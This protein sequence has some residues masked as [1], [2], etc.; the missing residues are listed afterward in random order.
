MPTLDFAGN[1]LVN[2]DR[3]LPSSRQLDFFGNPVGLDMTRA[4]AAPLGLQGMPPVDASN[5][6]QLP[7]L[8]SPM[9]PQEPTNEQ[10]MIYY[11]PSTGD[12][13][14]NGFQFNQRNASQALVSRQFAA[15]PHQRFTLPDTASDWRAMPTQEYEAYLNTIENPSFGR[16][17]GESW[18]NAWRGMGDIAVG[19]GLAIDQATTGDEDNQ[20][21]LNARAS[22]AREYEE[23]APFM[24]QMRDVKNVGDAAT[25]MSQMLVQGVPWL[26]ETAVSMAIGGLIGGAVSGGVGAPA[27][28]VEAFTAKEALRAAS[29]QLLRQ[30]LTRGAE[31]YSTALA[32]RQGAA[33]LTREEVV[34][35]SGA[36]ADD[37]N[38]F[39]NF[40]E[41][42][43][44][45]SRA[46]VGG[47]G[48]VQVGQ[49]AGMSASNYLTGVGDIRNS[50]ADAGGDPE[51]A[52]AVANIWGLAIPYAF[53]ESMGDLLVTQPVANLLPGFTNVAAR[54]TGIVDQLAARGVNALRS[55]AI[56]GPAEGLEEGA[57]YIITQQGV[58]GATNRPIDIDPI[59]LLENVVGGALAGTGLGGVTG[60]LG[61]P[62]VAPPAVSTPTTTTP[63]PPIADGALSGS[64]QIMGGLDLN[65][66]PNDNDPNYVGYQEAQ[67]MRTS[68]IE[69]LGDAPYNYDGEGSMGGLD[70]NQDP[71]D[72]N[73]NHVSPEERQRMQTNAI[74][75]VGPTTVT[76]PP[77]NVQVQRTP[78]E[79]FIDLA[80][81]KRIAPHEYQILREAVRREQMSDPTNP[82]Y[83]ETINYIN[84]A[85]AE[86]NTVEPEYD[87]TQPEL[88]PSDGLPTFG[89]HRLADPSV[90]QEKLRAD[91]IARGR[92]ADEGIQRTDGLRG[93]TPVSE[94]PA[95]LPSTEK[96][97][98]TRDHMGRV[99]GITVTDEAAIKAEKQKKNS[100][101]RREKRQEKAAL[102]KAEK[103]AARDAKMHELATRTE[104]DKQ[105][106]ADQQAMRPFGRQS[107]IRQDR[108]EAERRANEE[109]TK[110]TPFE[111]GTKKEVNPPKRNRLQEAG[112][113]IEEAKNAIPER[114]TKATPKEKQPRV[115]QE[116][117]RGNTAD[118][119]TA[120]ESANTSGT[121]SV[122]STEVN[123]VRV[124]KAIAALL[125]L[126]T[127]RGASMKVL[128]EVTK[129]KQHAAALASNLSQSDK[130]VKEGKK[131]RNID[132]DKYTWYFNNG[133]NRADLRAVIEYFKNIAEGLKADKSIISPDAKRAQAFHSQVMEEWNR[134]KGAPEAFVDFVT[135]PDYREEVENWV[136]SEISK[137]A[138]KVRNTAKEILDTTQNPKR[139]VRNEPTDKKL[140]ELAKIAD[141][142]P[143]SST[144][145]KQDD[146]DNPWKNNKG[147]STT[148]TRILRRILKEDF[149]FTFKSIHP[150]TRARAQ[151]VVEEINAA[152][153]K[154]GEKKSSLDAL[155]E[156]LIQLKARITKEEKPNR[157]TNET[158]LHKVI[159]ES[160]ARKAVDK[161]QRLI[162]EDVRFKTTHVL[163]NVMDILDRG[164]EEMMTAPNGAQVSLMS[165]VT[166]QAMIMKKETPEFKDLSVEAVETFFIQSHMQADAFVVPGYNALFVFA[167]YMKDQRHFITTLEHEYIAHG[168][169][170]ALFPD[171]VELNMFLQ[172]FG[173]IPGVQEMRNHL[174]AIKPEYGSKFGFS[175]F[176]QLEEV[177]AYHSMNGPLALERL[178]SAEEGIDQETRR[179]LWEDLKQLVKNWIAKIF[180]TEVNE[181]NDVMNDIVAALREHAIVGS[182]PNLMSLLDKRGVPK[183][184]DTEREAFYA[185][186]REH[187]KRA[188]TDVTDTAQAT[189]EKLA[190]TSTNDPLRPYKPQDYA[191]DALTIM[192][193]NE[194]L[195]DK[196]NEA[197]TRGG[198]SIKEGLAKVGRELV[199]MN[200]MALK[201]VLIEKM[202]RIMHNTIK[203]ARNLMTRIQEQRQYMSKTAKSAWVRRIWGD[204]YPGSNPE[205]LD[206]ANR[207]S[208]IA[209]NNRIATLSDSEVR[210][211]ARLRVRNLNGT[212]TIN[213]G[214]YD[215]MLKRGTLTKEEFYN[216]VE[217][218]TVDKNGEVTSNGIAKLSK[219]VIDL[220][221]E[222][223]A[224]ESRLMAESALN[225]LV[226]TNDAM[227]MRNETS[228]A[229]LLKDLEIKEKDR[230]FVEEA[231]LRMRK[232]Y[233]D[234]AF[235]KY[236][237]SNYTKRYDQQQM[238]YEVIVELQRAFHEKLKVADWT[239]TRT[240]RK[241]GTNTR[242]N[243]AFKWRELVNP[244][245]DVEPF[246]NQIRWF[247][248]YDDVV[249][250]N[251]MEQLNS[252]GVNKEQQFHAMNVFQNLITA[253]EQAYETENDV[254][255]SIMGNYVEMTR[256]G[257]WRVALEIRD[258]KG[259][260][261]TDIHP[262]VLANL[263]TTYAETKREAMKLQQEWMEEF[264]GL[265]TIKNLEGKEVKVTF[266]VSLAIA[267]GTKTM[268]DAPKVREFLKVAELAGMTL[269][270]HQMKV[271]ANLIESAATR[272]RLGLQRAGT[273]GADINVLHNNSQTMTRR[274]WQAAKTS[275]A[276]M[277]ES[278]MTDRDNQ[279]GDW[280]HLANLQRRFDIANRGAPISEAPPVTFV[281]SKAAVAIAEQELL[282]YAEQLR[283][284][285]RHS[286]GR[287]TVN[288]RTTK[289]ELKL[290]ITGEAEAY[291]VHAQALKASLEKGTIEVNLNDMLSKTGALRQMAVVSQL[292]T[293]ASGIMNAFTPLTHLPWRLMAKHEKTGYGEGFGMAEV[294]AEIISAVSHIGNVFKNLAD[295][296]AI[297]K[298][299][300][301][302]KAGNNATSLTLA[303]L[304]AIYVETLN[305]VLTPQQ[306]YSL[307]GGTESNITNLL[308][309]NLTTMFLGPFS[310]FE[311][312][313][314]RVSFLAAYRLM[315]A[316]YIA[317]GVSETALDD[318]KS[319]EY[320]K[321][322]EDIERVVFDTQGDY[323]NINR[324]RSFRGDW[325]Q[326]LLQYKMFPLN[327]VLLI[328]NLPRKEQAMMLGIIFLLS[329]L[330]GEPFADDFADIY[331]TLLQKL[332]FRHD[333]IELEL[334]NTL[335]G[336]MPGLSKWIMHGTVDT[337]FPIGA[338]ISSRLAMN[339][340]IPLT[341]ILRPEADIGRELTA[342]LG[343]AYAANM[344]A[345]EWA[346]TLADF[347]LQASGAKPRTTSWENMFVEA[348]R[349]LPQGQVRALTEAAMMWH[350]GEIVDSQG[351]LTSDEV[352]A[353]NIFSRALAFYP[354]EA[355]KA[356]TAVR[357]DRMH[358]GYM[359]AIRQRFILA[360]AMAYKNDNRE[361]ME[362]ISDVVQDWNDA[363]E[364]T[365]Q[366]DMEIRNFRSAG[367]RAGR[368]ARQTAV[369]R[370]SNAAPDY[371]D[372]DRLAEILNADTEADDE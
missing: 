265:H 336:I 8:R 35:L 207:M 143:T 117:R 126:A 106:I 205:Q 21:L 292:G 290:K 79:I 96:L 299:L 138:V 196:L 313:T 208:L 216:G 363:V 131:P 75:D 300:D 89:R 329:G 14:V 190:G 12:I 215:E 303:E 222:I 281:R 4:P 108:Y 230:V 335:E 197:R 169:L 232:L 26:V 5:V 83:T 19:A 107:Q 55:A 195:M 361:E 100:A 273:P 346:G 68:A 125:Y 140:D 7:A 163:G 174:L 90:A 372:I 252:V 311:A 122:Q 302:A 219:E 53:V 181:A 34:R 243:D 64:P 176:G 119:G 2:D 155:Y 229:E 343:P 72:S 220:G 124:D 187:V 183:I 304:E 50:I 245:K 30:N 248:E 179:T 105:R 168:G 144:K 171:R 165:Y 289:G 154:A 111:A 326:Y 247:L 274:S 250:K 43:Y 309:R 371:S 97:S 314:R 255:Q 6:P 355:S 135:D 199:T 240:T 359:R 160:E 315:K 332:G 306:T 191:S 66:N 74:M 115:V 152:Q 184:T 327:T 277:L 153:I 129:V 350:S 185:S 249:G 266:D 352:N 287:P 167:D 149:N 317:A 202:M 356:N 342:A 170:A 141:N 120:S 242:K 1:P 296:A 175:E 49:I 24:M 47:S 133:L 328:K 172:R 161:I 256:N 192:R 136:N 233:A 283:H 238:A 159:S 132:R 351:R 95:V 310:A 282:R 142:N 67:A 109:A 164:N 203:Y 178:L 134:A 70:L 366:E 29:R 231:L 27:G 128:A 158:A 18:E 269:K 322:M 118:T 99:K 52:D 295:S 297:K 365:G 268:G 28:A 211:A 210:N 150:A 76:P 45:M 177:I 42:A 20:W 82:V 33:A 59:D 353:L 39:F 214:V 162:N 284:M 349:Q 62:G 80:Q 104:E 123:Q 11:S 307:T 271:I 257:E 186:S 87:W 293:I 15:Q 298:L 25:Y 301:D 330:K 221:Y 91:N 280:E 213:T 344:A 259:K 73:P 57:Q 194:E 347:A 325:M 147:Q 200:D 206:A 370:T 338:T 38:R 130:A 261:Y 103:Q 308:W 41:R 37:V 239:D 367:I 188:V 110:Q 69:D 236:S 139:A 32:R 148:V 40:S 285:A 113:R 354:L 217:Q 321:L 324:P 157:S 345:I 112:K 146:T 137:L 101:K 253:E 198:A 10:S 156:N 114:S 92:A 212:Y 224:N 272:K 333:S 340:I 151:K 9:A 228:I 276:W 166:R 288:V 316:R 193:G 180:G 78:E 116:A 254:I 189:Q 56:V 320:K 223:Y 337:L 227:S 71:N 319:A 182:S 360:Y 312:S 291:N 85:E 305:G 98:V 258:A 84:D 60:A 201:S 121:E 218:F 63:T 241:E 244:H 294:S 48:A 357:L 262:Q 267:P 225:T 264:K 278:V 17:M 31:A 251:R 246:V 279:Y 362:R 237:E 13:V 16:R 331:D 318:P 173:R 46:G 44:H 358:T 51:S 58:S 81:S 22:L 234:I 54:S 3:N 275:Q 65:Q 61:R 23:N 364:Q 286:M 348:F 36:N 226:A 341:G 209:T 127:K 334:T 263:P 260:E 93:R 270:P 339:D 323:S 235:Y 368:A 88:L 77:V 204:T 94:T 369:Q 145:N 86:Q 102:K